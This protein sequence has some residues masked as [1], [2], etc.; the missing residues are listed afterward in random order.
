[1]RLDKLSAVRAASTMIVFIP[2]G[3]TLI[4]LDLPDGKV[5]AILR[6][7][8]FNGEIN[9]FRAVQEALNNPIGCDRL[10]EASSSKRSICII[11]SDYTRATPNRILLPPII[12]SLKDAGVKS[13]GIKVLIAYGLHKPAPRELALEFLGKDIV[14]E[15]NVVD[16]DAEREDD[17]TYIGKT[18]FGTKLSVNR[19]IIDSDLI[20]LTGL[21]EP[22]FFA[23][24]SGGRKA[25]LP[26]VAGREAI[27]NNHGFNMIMHPYA[28]YGFLEGNP[29]HEDMVEAVKMIR[30]QMYMV[31]VV[32]D[33]RHRVTRAFAGDVFKAHLTGVR[34]LDK[35][36]RVKSPAKADIVVT[37]NGGYP[38]DRDLYQAVKGMATGELV[39]KKG[40]VIVVFA[41]CV[42]GVGRGHEEFY[43]LMAEAKTPDEV[44]E[45][46]RREEPIKDQWQAQIMARILREMRV[47]IVTKNV[48]HSVIEEM[49][50]IP[51]SSPEEAIEEARRIVRNDA[52][53]IAIPEGP[54]IIPYAED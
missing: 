29:I 50:M 51:S 30:R 8:D 2:Y 44:L 19:Q 39:V 1:M 13:E 35:Y 25:I 32:I 36:I 49:H 53:I 54:Y 7:R 52:K 6:S 4:D 16:H 10:M 41:E 31:N 38:L 43:H 45:R 42:D 48:K 9:E 46:I 18:S 24:Y 11:V 20:I 15:V 37:S 5:L 14:E 27:F 28:R 26:G 23:G 12:E 17:L 22:H 21:I 33:K 3:K 34:F 40:G 47:I